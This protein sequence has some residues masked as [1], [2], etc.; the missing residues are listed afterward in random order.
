MF[1]ESYKEAEIKL[2]RSYRRKDVDVTTE[3]EFVKNAKQKK[4]NQPKMDLWKGVPKYPK[5]PA[6]K[7]KSS[8]S[9]LHSQGLLLFKYYLVLC[10]S[11]ILCLFTIFIFFE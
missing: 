7:R 8:S 6:P 3:E 5:T 1:V 2:K 9:N 11:F 4:K 10:Y